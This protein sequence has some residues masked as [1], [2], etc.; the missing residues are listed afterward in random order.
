MKYDFTKVLDREGKDA[1]AADIIPIPNVTVKEGYS[2]IPM[3]IAD[4][5]FETAPS[6]Q[7]AIRDRLTHGAFGYFEASAEQSGQ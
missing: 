4:M 1:L 6:I 2:K 7:E 3:W 5:N